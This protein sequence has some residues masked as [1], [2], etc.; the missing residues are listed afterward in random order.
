M[1]IAV[2]ILGFVLSLVMVGAAQTRTVTNSTLQK[3]QE[4]RLA[5]ER[6]YRENYARLGLPSPEE[7]DRQRDLDMAA[8]LQLAEQLRQ[9]R[10]EKERLELERRNL[11]LEAAALNNGPDDVDQ[12]VYYGGYL[13]GYGGF[14][15]GGRFGRR[16]GFFFPNRGFRSRDGY[17]VTPVGVYPVP[18]PQPQRLFFRSGRRGGA[19]I[20][21]GRH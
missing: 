10:L 18:N 5:A 20:R 11:E 14:Y 16:G 8:R 12:G 7:L 13:G 3:F 17:R 15:S 21:T 6:D 4:K 19:I 2:F 9:A 1:K